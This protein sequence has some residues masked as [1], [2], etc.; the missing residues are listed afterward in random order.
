M[1]AWTPEEQREHRK[2]WI[3]A[4]KS[5]EYFAV[6]GSLKKTWDSKDEEDGPFG[7]CV[8]GIGCDVSGLGTWEKP[9][10]AYSFAYV[11]SEE[12]AGEGNELQRKDYSYLPIPVMDYYGLASRE[13]MYHQAEEDGMLHTTA[14]CSEFDEGKSLKQMA[15]V[16]EAEPSGLLQSQ[17][18]GSLL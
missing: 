7:Y 4:L 8:L 15:D 17:L 5:G 1:T 12:N 6:R 16:I 9:G 3:E 11:V 14:L 10:A 2:Q 18:Q 13:G